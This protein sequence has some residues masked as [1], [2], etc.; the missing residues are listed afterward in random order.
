MS[1]LNMMVLCFRKWPCLPAPQLAPTA[2]TSTCHC[3]AWEMELCGHARAML[4][5]QYSIKDPSPWM[6]GFREQYGKEKKSEDYTERRP[7]IKPL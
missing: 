3:H 6:L 1:G 4:L 2:G 5:Q 7:C